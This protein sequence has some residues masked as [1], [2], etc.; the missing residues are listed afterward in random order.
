MDADPLGGLI[1]LPE[2]TFEMGNEEDAYP[3][4]GEGPVREVT[5]SGFAI[6]ATAVTNAEF[7]EFVGAT[8]HRTTAEVEGWSFV[9]AGLLPDDFPPTRAVLGAEW[10]RQVEGAD[11]RHPEGPD[12]R[13]TADGDRWYHPVVHVSWFDAVGFAA[14]ADGRLPTEAQWEYAARGGLDQKRLPWGDE[15]APNGRHQCNIF[16][17]TFPVEDTAE[18]GWA[19]TCPVDEYEPNGYGLYNCSGNVWE[20][21]ADWF[22]AHHPDEDPLFDPSGPPMGLDRVA[23]GG[24]YLCHDS[25]CH[26][27]R[28]GAHLGL[29]PDSTLGHHGFRLAR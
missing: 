6:S 1:E 7:A 2:G 4:D 19:G 5:L 15:N 22:T 16:T 8:G 10:W 29:L 13:L 11:W 27:Y 25:Y 17:G 28:V 23:K 18:D 12:S 26:R 21:C 20:W 3:A 9:F 24:S 14:W